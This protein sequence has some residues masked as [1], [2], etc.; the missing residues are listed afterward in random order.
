MRIVSIESTDWP[1]KL[2]VNPIVLAYHNLVHTEV[3]AELALLVV[4]GDSFLMHHIK[5]IFWGQTF[6]LP[7]LPPQTEGGTAKHLTSFVAP[8]KEGWDK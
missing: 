5:D 7:H 1:S 8:T 2:C 4:K 6:D 3:N